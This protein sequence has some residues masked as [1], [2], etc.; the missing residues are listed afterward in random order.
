M[1]RRTLLKS[2]A[3]PPVVGML[4]GT[5]TKSDAREIASTDFASADLSDHSDTVRRLR[6]FGE[7]S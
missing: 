7:T 6:A 2:L 1:N 3:S 4:M 5:N